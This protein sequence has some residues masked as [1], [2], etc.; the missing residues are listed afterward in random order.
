MVT[1]WMATCPAA[2]HLRPSDYWALGSGQSLSSGFLFPTH[3][4]VAPKTQASAQEP[5]HRWV[6]GGA[7]HPRR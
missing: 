1:V 5:R 6:S 3:V 4:C 2:G 7:M